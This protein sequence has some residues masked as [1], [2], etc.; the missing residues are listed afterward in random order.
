MLTER[1]RHVRPPGPD[2]PGPGAAKT[3]GS[4]RRDQG[5]KI[6]WKTLAGKLAQ[7]RSGGGMPDMRTMMPIRRQL[8]DMSGEDL[9]AQLDEFAALDLDNAV[10][11]QMRSMILG[12]LADKDPR[13][14]I[15]RFGT[16]VGAENSAARWTLQAFGKWAE[17]EPAAAAAWLDRQIAAGK[18]ESKSLDGE[19]QTILRFEA[20]VLGALL[21]IDPAAAT[22]RVAA[23]PEDQRME[24]FQQGY[25]LHV[26]PENEAAYA[27]LLR[28]S[29]PP[30]KAAGLLADKA[31]NLAMQG[32]YERVDGFIASVNA[33]DGEREAIVFRLMNRKLNT[34]LRGSNGINVAELDKA[35]ASGGRPRHPLAWM[36]PPVRHWQV[37]CSMAPTSRGPPT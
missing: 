22:A 10:R 18:L 9:C 29:V 12:V 1:I 31:D 30:D 35:R 5:G 2:R 37:W 34:S 32:G 36:P 14:L 7:S 17:S 25:L 33:T 4:S 28:D 21:D 16:E 11:E 15:E 23:M 13:L 27:K 8:L 3:T 19:N 24:L 26:T 6:D 20:S